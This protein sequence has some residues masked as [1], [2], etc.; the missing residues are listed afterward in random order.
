MRLRTARQGANAGRSFWG[1]ARYPACRATI[2]AANTDVQ[3]TDAA[4]TNADEEVARPR[5][6][7]PQTVIAEPRDATGQTAFYQAAALPAWIVDQFHVSDLN[8]AVVRSFAQWRLDYPLP[9]DGGID[10]RLRPIL[11][12]VEAPLT[13]GTTPHCSPLSKTL[14]G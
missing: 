13:R 9:L 11:A 5:G 2:D 1:C 3:R 8:P 10:R 12:I 4:P 7:F 14:S 6:T